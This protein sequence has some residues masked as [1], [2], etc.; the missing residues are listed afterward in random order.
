MAIAPPVTNPMDNAFWS[1]TAAER[2]TVLARLRAAPTPAFFTLPVIPGGF[3]LL[4][5]HAD[6]L[7]ASR[8]PEIFG[9]EP[10]A[11]TLEDAPVPIRESTPSMINLDDPRHAR[12]RRIVSRAFTPR[13]IKRFEDDVAAIAR[14][15][16]DELL[17]RG[18]CDFVTNVAQPMPLEII[19]AMMGVPASQYAA[20]VEATD[21]ILAMTDPGQRV[22]AER[23]RE[24]VIFFAEL[25]R[26]L[27][28]LRR[29]E[30]ADDLITALVRADV[31]GESLSEVDR[32]SVV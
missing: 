6:V 2:E 7:E 18:P 16:V 13:M 3:Y 30:P 8:H 14:R 27:G 1:N 20:V 10:A 9:S 24:S 29:K 31:N 28:E 23:I 26:D 22:P 32:K 21:V 15:I 11:T 19:C 12:L 17:E 25:M 5:R 4:T